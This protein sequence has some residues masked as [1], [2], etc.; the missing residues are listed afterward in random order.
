[1]KRKADAPAAPTADRRSANG[2]AR[3][4]DGRELTIDELI[5]DIEEPVDNLF[6]EKQRRL[7]PQ[8]LYEGWRGPGRGRTF[9]AAS[10]VGV[11]PEKKQT[12][13][14]PDVLLSLDV[15]APLD[16]SRKEHR[17]YF[18]WIMGKPP[19]VVFEFVSDRR[20]GEEGHKKARYAQIGVLYYVIFDPERWLRGDVLRSY[21]LRADGDYHALQKHWFPAVGLGVTLW[22]GVYETWDKEWLRWCD[23]KGRL[24]LT[25]Q[26][27]AAR[28]RQRLDKTLRR[29][30]KVEAQLRARGID[31]SP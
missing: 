10:D 26:E 13:I 23:A 20:G 2:K 19:D 21:E 6:I 17:S 1:M 3:P 9:L 24:I 4:A 18:L 31:P 7:L 16:P 28:E 27:R 15:P 14:A 29:L 25:G 22:Q 30:K 12:P 8:A 11:F 5:T